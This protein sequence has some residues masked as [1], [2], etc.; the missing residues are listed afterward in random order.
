MKPKLINVFAYLL[1]T[2]FLCWIPNTL[3]A[4]YG[5]SVHQNNHQRSYRVVRQAPRHIVQPRTNYYYGHQS[6]RNRTT[7]LRPSTALRT[8][9]QRRTSKVYRLDAGDT[10]SIIVNGVLGDYESA[11]INWPRDGSDINPGIGYPVPVRENGSVSLPLIGEVDVR[12]LS[13]QEAEKKIEKTYM[14]QQIIAVKNLVTVNL[15]RK[16][17][18]QVLVVTDGNPRAL[19]GELPRSVTK[20]NIPADDATTL[21]ALAE[22]GG[23]FDANRV[24][25]IQRNQRPGLQDGDVVD[26]RLGEARFFFAGGQLAAG[27]Y[28]LPTGRRLTATQAIAQAGGNVGGPQFGPSQLLITRGGATRSFDV[29]WLYANP[30]A[31]TIQPGDTLTLRSTAGDVI[32]NTA[33]DILRLRGI[34]GF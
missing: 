22:S 4:Q 27:R 28:S 34:R 3:H 31:V 32:G 10:L 16:R 19:P 26:A 8:T 25:V 29:N 5:R 13:V 17:T 20:V 7:T 11:P 9:S 1:V 23:Y 14:D 6:S 21:S 12:G 15:M 2:G 33:Q 24:R 18:V 30:N